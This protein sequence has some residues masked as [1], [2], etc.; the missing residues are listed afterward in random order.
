VTAPEPTADPVWAFIHA[1]PPHLSRHLNRTQRL[2]ALIHVAAGHGWTTKQ[3]VAEASRDQ[4]GVV[5]AGALIMH[6]LERC[7][8]TPPPTPG[9][10]RVLPFCSPECRDNAGWVLDAAG[11]P[12]KKC[13]CRRAS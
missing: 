6:R 2:V 13:A 12:A 7:A 10:L 8:E 1:L 4:A 9:Q 11:M 3:L 5:N